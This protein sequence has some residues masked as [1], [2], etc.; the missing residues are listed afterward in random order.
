M[1]RD[2][3]LSV[4]LTEAEK[5]HRIAQLRHK[6]GEIALIDLLVMQQRVLSASSNKLAV[7]RLA[8]EQRVN[9]FLALG[10][11]WFE[12]SNLTIDL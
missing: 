10:G 5:A 12:K 6:E 8:L 1:Q 2:N 7:Q 3:E 11:N 4:A 9:L